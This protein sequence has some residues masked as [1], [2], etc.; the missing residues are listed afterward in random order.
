MTPRVRMESTD[1]FAWLAGRIAPEAQPA[2]GDRSRLQSDIVFIILGS[3]LVTRSN[4]LTWSVKFG[5]ENDL[6]GH[7]PARTSEHSR[8]VGIH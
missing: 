6:E 7:N 1:H 3:A 2:P 8:P 4:S 5:C